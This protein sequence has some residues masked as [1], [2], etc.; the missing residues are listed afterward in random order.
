MNLTRFSIISLIMLICTVLS[1]IYLDREIASFFY[2]YENSQLFKGALMLSHLGEA[3]YP[4]I[5]SALLYLFYRFK[6][7]ALH[8]ASLSALFFWG[9]IATGLSNNLLKMF[10]GKARPLQYHNEGEFGFSWFVMP[11]D[12]NHL[13]FP[14]GHTTTAFSVA[15]FLSLFFPKYLYLFFTYALMIAATRVITFNHY[16]SDVIAAMYFSVVMSYLIYLKFQPKE[17]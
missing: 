14:S 7:K 1:Y 12:Y 16:L 10:F 9:V 15:T 2:Q 5:V 4:L 17:A 11:N 13:S 3:T 8:K 6:T